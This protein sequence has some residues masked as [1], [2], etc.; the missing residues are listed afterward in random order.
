M[1][2]ETPPR[3]PGGTLRLGLGMAAAALVVLAFTLRFGDALRA[4]FLPEDGTDLVQAGSYLK[5]MVPAAELAMNAAGTVTVGLLLAVVVFLPDDYGWLSPLAGRCLRAASTSATAWTVAALAVAVL[6][7]ADLYGKP[8]AEVLTGSVL[9]AYLTEVSQGRA[10][11]LVVVTAAALSVLAHRPRTPGGAGPLLLLAMAGLLPPAF[12]GHAA[13]AAN[14]SL[15]AYSLAAHVLGAAVWI[16]GLLVLVAA[17]WLLRDQ[18]GEIVA[19]YSRLAAVCFAVV[20]ASGLV[21]AWIRLDGPHLGSRYGVLIAAKT[22]AL[23][24]L[25][26]LGWWHRRVSVPALRTGQGTGVF[27]RVAA[28]ELVVMAAT[29][30][31]AVGLSRTAPPAVAARQIGPAEAML[32]F[33]L[34]GPPDP[35]AYASGWRWDPLFLALVTAGAVLYAMAVVRLRRDGQPWPLSRTV[36]W[37]AG[38]LI[39][40]A[41]TCS[42]LARYSMVLTSAHL[43]QHAVLSLIAPIPL[44][45]GA[46][47]TLALRALRPRRGGPGRT[48]PELLLALVHSRPLRLLTRPLAGPVLLV[49]SLYGFYSTPLFE[50]SLWDHSLH[51]LA[52]LLFVAAGVL[53]LLPIIGPGSGAPRLSPA[54]RV[55]LILAALPLHACSGVA[56]MTSDE[57]FAPGWYRSLARP[58]GTSQLR[59]QHLGGALALALAALA[60]LLVLL[61]LIRRSRRAAGSGRG[62]AVAG[63]A[64]GGE[65]ADEGA[66]FG[67]GA[68]AL[69][70]GVGE[71]LED[72]G[73]A[74]P[75]DEGDRDA[76][77]GEA[78]GHELGVDA[79]DLG[80]AAVDEGG[81]KLGE[82]PVDGRVQRIGGQIGEQEIVEEGQAGAGDER[83]EQ[84]VGVGELGG[85][86]EIGERGDRDDAA[87]RGQTVPDRL[88][89]GGE[90]EE[91]AGGVPGDHDAISGMTEIQEMPVGGEAVVDHLG[92][93]RGGEHPVGDRQRGRPRGGRQPGDH[94]P[95]GVQPADHEPAAVQIEDDGPPVRTGRR[96]PRAAHPLGLEAGKGNGPRPGPARRHHDP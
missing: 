54:K 28:L 85:V 39:V 1:V 67:E 47:V 57:V 91:A 71:D 59:D 48:P 22:A 20:A 19:R 11:L 69:A 15:A 76:R 51:A 55:A 75:D 42:G 50:A 40:L 78:V 7:V 13:S 58:W 5:G 30:G 90:G 25:G 70:A 33:R 16:G 79:Q 31:L 84:E 24:G 56:I 73:L 63:G 12:T 95:M 18:L 23:A 43:V 53:Y 62:V 68:E 86:V 72:V 35:A 4:T 60:S 45:L 21:N 26:G 37:A 46:P 77:L 32:G 96:D 38:L 17:A 82:G 10:L 36:A 9:S 83:V 41:A 87:G 2:E 93:C 34:P 94:P 8:P 64:G 80:R 14:H 66:E 92:Q 3:P 89:R 65:G 88:E 49:A 81:R 44:L 61:I 6:S 74:V 52:M 27:V 29:M